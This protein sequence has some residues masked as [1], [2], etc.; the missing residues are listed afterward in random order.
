MPEQISD[1]LSRVIEAFV[2]A[3][4]RSLFA[5]L[6]T[7]VYLNK[8]VLGALKFYDEASKPEFQANW[9][10]L[11]ELLEQFSFES[12]ME[13]GELHLNRM[14]DWITSYLNEY[15]IKQ[16]GVD[17]FKV[18]YGF[19]LAFSDYL[20]R[21]KEQGFLRRS[22]AIY[23]DAAKQMILDALSE[24]LENDT[25]ARLNPQ[26]LIKL[27]VS[28][29]QGKESKLYGSFGVYSIF[30]NCSLFWYALQGAAGALED[31]SS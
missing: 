17:V 11:V 1:H 4:P 24:I 15:G 3:V 22:T 23:Q 14:N 10:K 26:M 21:L 19:G 27:R 6:E 18:G 12:D 5:A 16:E 31:K 7:G 20:D 9:S 28:A 25:G 13:L 30:K 29:Y 2:D 8:R